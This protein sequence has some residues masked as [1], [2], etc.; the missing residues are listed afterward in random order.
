VLAIC[1]TQ[2]LKIRDLTSIHFPTVGTLPEQKEARVSVMFPY[3]RFEHVCRHP[4]FFD[5]SLLLKT[6]M[7]IAWHEHPRGA[8]HAD[9]GCRG[10]LTLSKRL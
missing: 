1:L 2:G 6:L 9:F 10:V 5:V 4:F 8:R 3:P 7:G